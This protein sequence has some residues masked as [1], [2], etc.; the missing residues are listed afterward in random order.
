MSATTDVD[1]GA[2]CHSPPQGARVLLADPRHGKPAAVRWSRPIA[3]L[4]GALI[5]YAFPHPPS[6][7]DARRVGSSAP[8]PFPITA[9]PG[10][11]CRPPRRHVHP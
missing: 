5:P 6:F 2:V 11:P 10:A 8:A 4:S 9:S 7:R 3:V 1:S